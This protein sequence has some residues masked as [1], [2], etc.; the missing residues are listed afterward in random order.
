MKKIV[1][2]ITALG[3]LLC[4]VPVFGDVISTQY[5][6]DDANAMVI[7]GCES[8]VQAG[9]EIT[10][11]VFY[12]GES[13]SSVTPGTAGQLAAV[14][15]ASTAGG[16]HV[17]GGVYSRRKR[18]LRHIRRCGAPRCGLKVRLCNGGQAQ[19]D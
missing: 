4:A 7:S 11:S 15:T 3:M 13:Y 17:V 5:S 2:I 9:T 14:L 6:L 19:R 18:G 10:V 12:Q 8:G 1:S 16:R